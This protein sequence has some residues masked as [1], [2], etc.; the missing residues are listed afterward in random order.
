MLLKD[1]VAIVTGGARGMG[2]AIALRFA[3]E[4]C[5]SVIADVLDKD[6]EKTIADIKKAGK[7][8]IYIH[9]D[10]TKKA[11]VQDMV[12]KAVA[13]FKKIDIMVNCAGIG[14]APDTHFRHYRRRIR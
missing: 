4:G 9:T 12:A 10:V 11:N 14:R 5:S 7:D 8:A 6:G 1:R 2:R 3:K 13:K